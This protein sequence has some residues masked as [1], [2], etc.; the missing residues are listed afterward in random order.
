MGPDQSG[1]REAA[2]GLPEQASLTFVER[3]R[4]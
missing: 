2:S 3:G 1:L 4:S